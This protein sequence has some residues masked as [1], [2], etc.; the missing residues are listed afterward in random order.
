MRIKAAVDHQ[1]RLWLS[2]VP[3]G[4]PRQAPGLSRRVTRAAAAIVAACL[5]ACLAFLAGQHQQRPFTV[6]SGPVS[7]GDHEATFV[8]AGW[9]YG[10]EGNSVPWVD[11]QGETHYGSWPACLRELG[12]TAPVT[13]GEVPVTAP[14]GSSWRQVVWVDCRS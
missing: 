8:V 3:A 14:D 4:E 7:V 13:F 2:A 12:R 1:A 6:L 10:I 5:I 9:A 11:Q